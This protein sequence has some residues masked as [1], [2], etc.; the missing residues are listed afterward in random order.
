[1]INYGRN[2]P[3]PCGS[4]R[5]AKRCCG[6]GRG[7]GREELARA[8]LAVEARRAVLALV[9]VTG[10]ELRDLFEDLMELPSIDLSLTSVAKI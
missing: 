7:P 5:K 1:M 4:G 3:C 10:R 9:G 8:F 6:V 2:D